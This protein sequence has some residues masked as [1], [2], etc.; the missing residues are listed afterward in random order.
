MRIPIIFKATKLGSL[1]LNIYHRWD[2]KMKWKAEQIPTRM[3]KI[4]GQINFKTE[5]NEME[6]VEW[7][8]SVSPSASKAGWLSWFSNG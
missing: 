3:K 6:L 8:F 4:M 5:T 1:K 7:N 2:K